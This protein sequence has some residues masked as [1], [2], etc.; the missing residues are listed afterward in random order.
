V[1]QHDQAGALWNR[2][3][4]LNPSRPFTR[5]RLNSQLLHVQDSAS[6][7]ALRIRVRG[8]TSRRHPQVFKGHMDIPTA[9]CAALLTLA[10]LA[11]FAA[12][13]DSPPQRVALVTP[14]VTRRLEGMPGDDELQTRHA[15]IGR[16]A[17]EVDDVFESE[18]SLAAPYR[19]ANGLHIA[20]RAQTIASQLLFSSGDTYSRHSLDESERLLRGQ[21]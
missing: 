8:S 9:S 3:Q 7:A 19:L 17:V 6:P 2:Y 5:P 15:R 11:S 12:A 10:S 18:E 16:I 1:A 14:E 13:S 4:K 21:R 20:T